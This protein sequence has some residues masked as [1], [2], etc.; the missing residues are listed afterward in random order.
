MGFII[1]NISSIEGIVYEGAT[2]LTYS[3]RLDMAMA[4]GI[5]PRTIDDKFQSFSDAW[6]AVDD[7]GG[8]DAFGKMHTCP[9]PDGAIDAAGGLIVP[10]FADSHTH[11]VYA[12]SRHGEFLDKI[13]GL[14]YEEIAARGGGILNSVDLLRQ[15]SED[16]LFAQS[17]PRLQ[18]VRSQG[19]AFIEI[20]TGYGLNTESEI[21][22]LRVIARLAE[23]T[24]ILVRATF[25]GAHATPREFAGDTEGYTKMIIAEMLPAVAAEGIAQFVDVFCDRGF[26]TPAQT[27]R[28][29]EAAAKY[30]LR[31]KI[32]ANELAYDPETAKVAR[33]YGAVSAD[34]LE[35]MTEEDL[36]NGV[37]AK[38]ATMLPGTS[39]F[40]G[41]PYAPAR[42]AIDRG[43]TVALAS[44]FNP[45]SSPGGDMRFIWALGC[46]KM[47]L[48]PRE[49]L[50]ACTINGCYAMELSRRFG[51]IAPG[52]KA[53][54]ILTKPFPAL[55]AIPYLYTTPWIEKICVNGRIS[56]A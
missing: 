6:I 54:F 10:S 28:I 47:G 22:M 30:G 39:F 24:D 13:R 17:L 15:T 51:G 33:Q 21:K 9:N 41:M 14:S 45:G 43:M 37:G 53:N 29:L 25:L 40:L 34:H 18:Q 32:H 2:R 4:G 35:S 38:V 11:L 5:K 49:A 12:G 7:D 31:P 27:A 3:R 50:A 48:T 26:F 1:K 42:Q 52:K 19:T 44:D 8:I 16:D 55:E 20:K 46:I 23:A 56:N 36:K